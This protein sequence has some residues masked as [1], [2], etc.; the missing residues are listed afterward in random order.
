MKA[1]VNTMPLQQCNRTYLNYN[2][3]AA[4]SAFREGISENQYCAQ[5]PAFKMD[6]CRGDSGG[7]LQIFR[8]KYTAHVIGIVS[9]GVSCGSDLPSIY[10]RV[11]S[12]SDWIVSHV[13]PNEQ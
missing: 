5:D 1:E 8:N 7:P 13:W 6:S 9:F 11:A 2:L 12:Y 4:H 3:I 10:T